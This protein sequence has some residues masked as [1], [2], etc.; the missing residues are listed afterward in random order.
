M[1]TG[2]GYRLGVTLAVG[3]LLV[4][5]GAPAQ[6]L[7][8]TA[9]FAPGFS[10]EAQSV[11]NQALTFYNTTFTGTPLTAAI[12]FGLDVSS[13]GGANAITAG[14][15]FAYSAV[16]SALQNAQSASAADAAAVSNL[17]ASVPT[18]NVSLRTSYGNSARAQQQ[19]KLHVF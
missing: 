3:A 13:S 17:P 4:G 18:G 5:V 14:S 12:T 10:P 11:V 1:Q 7:T 16:K 19:P 9:D 2:R 6:A 15:N 8:L